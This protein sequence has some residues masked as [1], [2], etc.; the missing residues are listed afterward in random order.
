MPLMLVTP[1][2]RLSLEARVVR[3]RARLSLKTVR[4][5]AANEDQTPRPKVFNHSSK[6]LQ[7]AGSAARFLGA[8]AGSFRLILRQFVHNLFFTSPD[9]FGYIRSCLLVTEECAYKRSERECESCNFCVP[10]ARADHRSSAPA[11]GFDLTVRCHRRPRLKVTFRSPTKMRSLTQSGHEI[12]Q[13]TLVR[14]VRLLGCA[15]SA[16]FV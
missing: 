4:P 16:G 6:S 11:P 14:I 1:T 15:Y 2:L 12:V 13:R 3:T 10:T 5:E 8:Y 7:R 9:I